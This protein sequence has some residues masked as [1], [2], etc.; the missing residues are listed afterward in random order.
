MTI[1]Q[2]CFLTLVNLVGDWGI[3][4]IYIHVCRDFLKVNYANIEVA[5][6]TC[7]LKVIM[8][9]SVVLGISAKSVQAISS[10]SA[11]DSASMYTCR[12]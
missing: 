9:C 8:S 1:G 10:R 7:E 12:I 2:L 6:L 4:D 3:T 5:I 11:D